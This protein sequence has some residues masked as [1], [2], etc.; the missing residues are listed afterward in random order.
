MSKGTRQARTL[1]FRATSV[2]ILALVASSIAVVLAAP[3]LIVTKTASLLIDKNGDGLV[4]P[5]DRLRYT[6]R[7][8]NAGDTT[9]ANVVFTDTLDPNTTLVN[10]SVKTSPVAVDDNYTV[11]GNTSIAIPPA[12]GLLSND[13]GLPTPTALAN[14]GV[15]ANGAS[16]TVTADGGFTYEP[17][18]GFTGTD[19][20]SYTVANAN[21][22]DSAS[23]VV[24][25]MS[26]IWFINNNANACTSSCDGRLSHPFTSIDAFRTVNDGAVG[27]PA[28]NDSI[29]IYESGTSYDASAPITLLAGQ[30]VIGQDSTSTLLS[31][32]GLTLPAGNAPLP[33]TNSANGVIVNITAPGSAINLSTNNQLYGFSLGQA[34]VDISGTNFGSLTVR[35]VAISNTIGSAMSLITGTTDAVFTSVTSMGGTNNVSLSVGGSL[36][37][38]NG[39]LSGASSTAL[40]V[41]GGQGTILYGGNINS[42]HRTVSISGK[43]GGTVTLGGRV[44]GTGTGVYINNNASTVVTF[45]GGVNLNTGTSNA[46]DVVSN[47][48]V[49]VNVTGSS[50]YLTT[51]SGTALRVDNS[52]IGASGLTFRSI[53]SDGGGSAGIRLSSTGTSGGLTVTGDSGSSNNGSGGTIQNKV[54]NGIELFSTRNVS[55]GYMV[56]QNNKGSG[57]YGDSLTNFTLTRSNIISNSDTVDGSEAN[58][59]FITLLGNNT[60]GNSTISG[61]PYDNIRLTPTSST[62]SLTISGSTIGPNS[63]ATGNNGITVI[64]TNSA[65]V[66]LL[67]DGNTLI[68]GNRASGVQTAFDT[69]SVQ[70]ITVTNSTLNNNNIGVDIGGTST[71]SWR[72]NVTNNTLTSQA[73]DAIFVVADSTSSGTNVNGVISGNT[74]GTGAP[75]TGSRDQYGIHISQREAANLVVLVTNNIIHNTDF[76]GILIR[77]GDINP[78][79]GTLSLTLTSNTVTIPDDNSGFPAFPSGIQVRSRQGTTLCANIANN[80]SSGV[81]PGFGFYLR[82]SDTSVFRLQGFNSSVATTLANNGN[83]GTVGS[84]GTINS[85]CTP[86]LPQSAISI[87]GSL[88]LQKTVQPLTNIPALETT[89]A[90]VVNVVWRQTK[91][92]QPAVDNVSISPSPVTYVS[93][94]DVQKTGWLDGVARFI[95][96]PRSPGQAISA[97]PFALPQGKT[98]TITFDADIDDPIPAGVNSVSNQGVAVGSNFSSVPSDD[99][100]TP[101]AN[102]PTVTLL[103]VQADLSIVKTVTPST[104]I[105]GALVTYTIQYQNNGPQASAG[106]IISDAVPSELTGVIVTADPPVTQTSTMP[107]VW[108]VGDLL[109]GQGGLITLTAIVSPNLTADERFTNTVSI[110]GTSDI[111]PENNTGVAAIDVIPSQ[112]QLSSASYTV[113]ENSGPA[114]ITVTVTPAPVLAVTV[115]YS[116][117][118]GTASG[119]TDYVPTSGQ[120]TFA[121]GQSVLTFTVPITDDSVYEANE[122]FNVM[123]SNASNASV[124]SPSLA[125][126]TIQEND[127]QPS[128]QFSRA[129]FSVAEDKTSAT[130]TVTLDHPSSFTSTATVKSSDGTASSLTDYVPVSMSLQLPPFTTVVTFSVA[131][132]NDHIYETNESLTLTLSNPNGV[133]L[134]TPSVATL[135]IIENEVQP[136][137]RFLS[138]VYTVTESD[139]LV[140]ITA[141]LSGP[142]AYTITVH[143]ATADGTAVSGIDYTSTSG[144]LTYTP[145][146][147]TALFAVP[148]MSD[149]N[150][151]K[152]ESFNVVLSNPSNATIA[153]VNPATVVIFDD[154]PYMLFLPLAMMPPP[155]VHFS[156][157][158]YSVSESAGPAAVT[159]TLSAPT[160][161]TATVHYSISNGTAHSPNDFVATSGVITFA[162]GTTSRVLNVDVVDDLLH[163][164][165]ET[166]L[167]T[168]NSAS[169]LVLSTPS[170]S[171]LVIL[172]DDPPPVA[173]FNSATYMVSENGGAA[174]I[175]VSLNTP[176]G[177]TATV[178]AMTHNGTAIASQDYTSTNTLLTFAPGTTQ[179]SFSVPI[180]DDVV[181]ENNETVLLSLSSPSEASVGVPDQ[182][183]LVITND[184]TAPDLIVQSVIGSGNLVTVVIRN[185]GSAPVT[186]EFWVDAYISPTIVPTHVN[187]IWSDVGTRGLAWG[188]TSS[189]LP[190]KPGALLTL[191]TQ[192][193]YYV[194]AYSYMGG[195]IASGTPL[196][197]QVDS[198]DVATTYGAVLESHEIVG[199]PYNNITGP[200]G[201]MLNPPSAPGISERKDVQTSSAAVL[202]PARDLPR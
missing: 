126:V 109:P 124:G 134:G 16:Y 89:Q 111:T 197:A 181:Y 180:V 76:E 106:V 32:T 165:N 52:G 155:S 29:F 6:V 194:P 11:I 186:N 158:V 34:S 154:D 187:Q 112:V 94:N 75:D 183:T 46:F 28:A 136:V 129:N 30:R 145:G 147:T 102:D 54:G 108:D 110:T 31:L 176:S 120:L 92:A 91:A 42:S 86:A 71:A 151:E 193:T 125:T 164:H 10:G 26:R 131:I 119:S 88:A 39:K 57:I 199:G 190:I 38:G 60:I 70:N 2:S 117:S 44:N 20:F 79:S 139:T 69:A 85:S 196:Y 123:L 82:Q 152:T 162:P 66:N 15:T 163:E 175:T 99:P 62:G 49:A 169:N 150:A 127:T 195:P 50:N 192:S 87:G 135:D 191:T 98:I 156:S 160:S 51:T 107:Y 9:G 8:T 157:A 198:A 33:G 72:F 118:D 7:I 18:A 178:N 130:I 68:T 141:E 41:T 48:S 177:I 97:G 188:V 167:L 182:A 189:A 23:V 153:G 159:V 56:V 173:R 95:S 146:M 142:S 36:D 161:V 64:G 168:L 13:F 171:T 200:S 113:T 132:T 185:I 78:S 143:Y 59:R 172:D 138:G 65:L 133:S 12:S 27:H 80:T 115:V 24:N 128:V 170:T 114:V 166:V 121:P 19:A 45:S 96:G 105:P 74:I 25:V 22:T 179:A 148:I 184:E 137:V 149:S 3:N 4:N 90:G 17:P 40:L 53:T 93:A 201:I 101:A 1:I 47:P 122:Q 103:S 61:S 58:L 35:D 144:V 77:S 14:S 73:T 37:L 21:G 55:L 83:S 5:G 104:A 81:V 100:T 116:T 174:I 67:I 140:P 43:A 202:L 84:S 63:A